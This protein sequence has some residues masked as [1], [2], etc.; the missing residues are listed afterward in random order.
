MILPEKGLWIYVSLF[1]A[2][3]LFY[4]FNDINISV[5]KVTNRF[6]HM[7]Y[8]APYVEELF[9]L[10]AI[11]FSP[12]CGLFYTTIFSFNEMMHYLMTPQLKIIPI[13]KL[14]VIRFICVFLHYILFMIQLYGFRTYMKT[15]NSIYLLIF[16]MLAITT[17]L[18]WNAGGGDFVI[19]N[20]F[21]LVFY[22]F[23][24]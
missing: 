10:E 21:A 5:C 2:L 24:L 19:K 15:K 1:F 13:S 17:H 8:F 22:L 11:L 7:I 3:L 16:T 9:R 23:P 18:N 20:L 6:Q 12:A 4:L 14:I